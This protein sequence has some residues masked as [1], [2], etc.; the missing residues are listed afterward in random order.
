[1]KRDERWER[2]RASMGVKEDFR[3]YEID[4]GVNLANWYEIK[5]ELWHEHMYYYRFELIHEDDWPDI[6]GSDEVLAFILNEMVASIDDRLAEQEQRR[7]SCHE[8]GTCVLDGDCPIFENC[9]LIGK[10]QHEGGAQAAP[11]ESG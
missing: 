10:D 1:M 9:Y 4:E 3:S 11:A 7:A 2:V 5:I 6:H 8:H